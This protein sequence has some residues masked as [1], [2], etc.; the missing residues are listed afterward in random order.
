VLKS[1]V[2]ICAIQNN[3]VDFQSW[4]CVCVFVLQSV[5][6]DTVQLCF[7][8]YECQFQVAVEITF[9]C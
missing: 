9:N 2:S 4:D 7:L 3:F 6:S 8:W 1:A 5:D